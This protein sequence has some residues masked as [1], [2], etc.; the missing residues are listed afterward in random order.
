MKYSKWIGLLSV[1]LLVIACL[2]PWVE[3]VS[4][5]IIVTGLRAEGTHFGK[6]GFMNLIMSGFAAIFFLIPTVGAKRAN[7]F[8]CAF[9]LAWAIR[10]YIIVS[11]CHGGECPVQK[12]GLYLLMLAALLMVIAAMFPDMKLK[13]PN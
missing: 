12:I 8:F 9:N 6:P 1:V 4:R 7:L 5:N 13:D 3:I 11:T 2:L 10:N